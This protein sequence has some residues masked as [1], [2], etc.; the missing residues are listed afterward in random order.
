MPNEAAWV[1]A[2]S[3]TS[4]YS[5]IPR[6]KTLDSSVRF[7]PKVIKELKNS[8]HS[9]VSKSDQVSSLKIKKNITATPTNKRKVGIDL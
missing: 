2:I 9:L 7:D 5:I 3:L 6:A 1:L 4:V 8:T